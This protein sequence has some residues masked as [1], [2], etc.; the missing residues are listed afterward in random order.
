MT[1]TLRR[2]DAS[3]FSMVEFLIAAFIMAIGLLGLV[4]LQVGAIAQ[5]S[6]GRG[7]TTA[8]YAANQVLQRVQ[9][10]GQYSY[11][12]KVTGA[13]PSAGFTRVYTDVPGTAIANTPFGG[14]NADG[15]QVTDSTGAN[16]AN[17]AT[18]VPDANKRSPVFTVSWA[19]RAYLGTAPTSTIQSQEFVVNV[20]WVEGAA[21]KYLSMSRTVRY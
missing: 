14:F 16:V 12:A 20:T 8:V 13:T 1:T 7:R 10:E 9:I 19:R 17:L 4:A 21:T 2:R 18:L 15:I 11:L 5:A 6:T 3:G